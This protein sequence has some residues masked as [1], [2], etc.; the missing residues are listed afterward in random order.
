MT[1]RALRYPLI[2]LTLFSSACRESN[3]LT[4]VS[5][6]LKVVEEKR[7]AAKLQLDA[8]GKPVIGQTAPQLGFMPSPARRTH[9]EWVQVDLKTSQVIH[10]IAL[11]PAQTDWNTLGEPIYKF[12][13]RFHVE[14]SEAADF[15]VN[16]RVADHSTVDFPDPGIG[17]IVW[18][19]QGRSA[20][21][22]RVTVFKPAMFALAEMMVMSG[23][24]NVAIQCP[25]TSADDFGPPPQWMV[26]NPPRWM[27]NNLV[28]GRTPLGPPIV[29]D[30]PGDDGLY[31]APHRDTHR[32]FMEL[33]LGDGLPIEEVRLHPIHGRGGVDLPG[34]AFPTKFRVEASMSP[35]FESPDMLY[36][37]G[38]GGFPNPGT[39]VVTLQFPVVKG[40]YVRVSAGDQ[41][42]ILG[43]SEIEV[44][45]N[46]KNAARQAKARISEPTKGREDWPVGILNDGYTSYGR[47]LE[48][49][50]WL[51]N[52][53]RRKVLQAELGHLEIRHQF[54]ADR[55]LRRLWWLSSGTFLLL[56]GGAGFYIY[57]QQRER[58]LELERFRQ[59]V[60]NDFHDEIGS[61][62]AAIVA[63][64][65][66]ASRHPSPHPSDDFRKITEIA[67]E[68][69]HAM[70]ETLWIMGSRS[71]TVIDL[72]KYLQLA[73]TRMLTG[74]KITWS[75]TVDHFP[76]EW[77]GEAR[78][79][80]F[81]FFK[82]ALANIVRHSGADAV[83]LSVR[84]S[85]AHIEL[86]IQDNGR[87]FSA[88]QE[89][90]GV[91]LRSLRQRATALRGS[92]EI[93]TTEGS[94]TCL[95]LR[96]PD[97]EIK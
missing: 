51:N 2:I 45:A 19:V 63:L 66:C 49:P 44:Y 61:N 53:T 46:G 43:L 38:T 96:L 5:P 67:R 4:Q 34:L 9:P 88:S 58:K 87:G 70:H 7:V 75:S 57:R 23:N 32:A 79:H 82:E 95:V 91:G 92:F 3:L 93:Q 74:Q 89:F 6:E 47:I 10:Q 33:D 22:V 84:R 41:E 13:Q 54:L 83:E 50:E 55:A 29:L 11:I 69:T 21:Y 31:A 18:T 16:E 25:V 40:R 52:W 1:S 15:S 24:R 72:M 94:G 28:D 77:S 17:P 27:S 42:P 65:E 97:G 60:A 59:Q 81:L 90:A 78:K 62:L 26:D 14:I 39:N 35:G 20:R 68:T 12:P 71:G 37:V 76:E 73:A 8:L 30:M 85:G 48:L 64:G 80:L 36:A 56:A 86:K